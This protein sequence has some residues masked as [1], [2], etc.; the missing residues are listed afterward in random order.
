MTRLPRLP[1][2]PE[3]I[4]IQ[5]SDGGLYLNPDEKRWLAELMGRLELIHVR[6]P[7]EMALGR[8]ASHAF[9]EAVKH[10]VAMRLGNH[11]AHEYAT[12][13]VGLESGH[14]ALDPEVARAHVVVLKYGLPPLERRGWRGRKEDEQWAR[15]ARQNL[16]PTGGG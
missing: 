3:Q 4:G 13:E 2:K 9:V 1:H 7:A 16:L 10:D 6:A 8:G 15:E 14:P 11:I 5:T 12:I